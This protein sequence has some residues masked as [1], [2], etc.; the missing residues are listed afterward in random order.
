MKYDCLQSYH[1]SIAGGGHQGSERTYH[2]LRN[3]YYWPN[4]YRDVYAHVQSCIACQK[5]KRHYHGQNAPLKPLPITDIFEILHIDILGPLTPTPQNEKYILVVVDSFS[6]WC[7][8]FDMKTQEALEI[9]DILFREIFT[10]YGAPKVLISDRGRNFM[11]KLVSA[12]HKQM[13]K[14]REETV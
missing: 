1:D 11:S 9:A 5:A 13:Q 12:L 7:E 10:R 3:K 8:A 4:M 6:K 2:A 14:L